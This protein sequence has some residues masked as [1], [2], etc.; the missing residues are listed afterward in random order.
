LLQ[1]YPI[2]AKTAFLLVG[3]VGAILLA[4]LIFHVH[5]HSWQK[6]IGVILITAVTLLYRKDGLV[7]TLLTPFVALALP[8]M[9]AFA[10]ALDAVFWPLRKL[11]EVVTQ[12]FR[13]TIAEEENSPSA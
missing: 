8:V 1:K 11:H 10:A 5:V 13:R 4:E 3:Y 6:F 12:V 7:K 9:G 2:L